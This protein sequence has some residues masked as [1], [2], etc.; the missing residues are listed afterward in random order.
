[1]HEQHIER[2]LK[3]GPDGLMVTTRARSVG[4]EANLLVTRAGPAQ[5]RN[6]MVYSAR[7]VH[8]TKILK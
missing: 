5:L 4:R 2:G 3:F 7:Q 6:M 1:M 8:T